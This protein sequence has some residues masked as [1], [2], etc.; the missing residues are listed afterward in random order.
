IGFRKWSN[1]KQQLLLND[2][3]AFL[4]GTI[5]CCIFPMTGYPPTD[6]KAW[7]KIFHTIKDHGLNH[8][9]FHSWCPPEAA[10]KV[11]DR[12]G[13]YLQVEGPIWL[14]EWMT[15]K[16]GDK[17]DHYTFFLE[18]SRRIVVEYGHHPSFCFF[19]CGNEI[20]G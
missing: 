8:V 3:P 20:R 7:E 16:L 5:D 15:F 19:S 9:R 13:L 4:R 12:L 14:D 2:H 11:A 6:E 1:E 10:F 18:E 17:S